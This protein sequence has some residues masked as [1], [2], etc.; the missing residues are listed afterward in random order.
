[1]NKEETDSVEVSDLPHRI[2]LPGFITDED[3]GLG[4]TMHRAARML[5]IKPCSSCQRR[6]AL[7]NRWIVFTG[8][9]G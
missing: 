8:R 7:L 9:T 4:D 3:I 2:R 6:T 1:M 5:G